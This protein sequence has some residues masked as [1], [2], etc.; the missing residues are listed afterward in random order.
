[1]MN[2]IVMNESAELLTDDVTPR[3]RSV[4]DLKVVNMTVGYEKRF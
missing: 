4:V 1:M 3:R 2:V